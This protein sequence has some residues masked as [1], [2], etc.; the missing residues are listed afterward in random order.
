LP[1]RQ[2]SH[3]RLLVVEDN[4]VNQKVAAHLL[5]RLG[6]HVEIA[7]NGEEGVRMAQS[8]KF[9]ILLMDCQMPVM[10]GFKATAEIRRRE[11]TNAHTTIVAMTA[12]ALAEDRER[13][14]QAG[15]DDYISKPINRAELVRVLERFVPSWDQSVT[16]PEP[17]R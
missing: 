1:E 5:E 10:D 9:D 6:C 2:G 17:T 13:C 16:V 3:C 7:A 8:G 15:M 4:R 12:N 14:L 11:G